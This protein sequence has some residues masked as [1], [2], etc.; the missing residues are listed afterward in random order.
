MGFRS[1]KSQTLFIFILIIFS[2]M[3]FFTPD[4]NRLDLE[5]KYAGSPSQ[6]TEVDGLRVHY[7][8]TGDRSAK[9]T[10]VL[11]HGFGSSLQTWDEWASD[12]EKN[13]RV[14]RLDLAGFGLTGASPDNNYSDDAD[15]ARLFKF[16]EK[17]NVQKCILV[18]HSMGG[19]IAWNFASSYPERL[20]GLALL[21]P[22][23]FPAPGQ[24]VGAK[25]Y[26]AGPLANLLKFFMP[27]FIIKKS[28]EPAFFDSSF[29]TDILLDRYYDMLRAPTVRTAI[30]QR[31][32][33]TITVDPVPKLRKIN[34]PTL[35]LWGERD[36]M[37]PAS[38][39]QDYSRVMPNA[40]VIILQRASHLLQEENAQASLASF[41]EFLSSSIK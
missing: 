31:M 24:I 11:L 15:V 2:F 5:L 14:I 4:L 36:Q 33:Q 8:D 21:A 29:M 23:G 10:V 17:I 26:D 28:L 25:P 1:K 32:S 35:L 39:S 18:G 27:K 30:L 9:Q 22:D 16:L 37:I 38:N 3:I 6:F 12:L 19:R 7:R 40:K 20:E 34:I 13:R 41:K